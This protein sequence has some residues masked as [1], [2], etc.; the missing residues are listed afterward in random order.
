M[1]HALS[2]LRF[3]CE[4][5]LDAIRFNHRAGS[6]LNYISYFIIRKIQKSKE[7]MPEATLTS[8]GQITVPIEVRKALALELGD[9]LEFVLVA[10]GRYEVMAVSMSVTS[11]KGLFDKPIKKVRIEDMN[12]AIKKKGSK[13][14]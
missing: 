10:P 3:K 7:I 6:F 13:V 1:G 14:R 8:K 12:Q 9:K 5:I 11:L 2:Y 4:A